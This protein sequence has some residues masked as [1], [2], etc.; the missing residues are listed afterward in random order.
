GMARNTTKKAPRD[1]F[2]RE[3][4]E[5]LELESASFAAESGDL[6]IAASMEE[7]EAQ[8]T[9]A[10]EELAREG[11]EQDDSKEPE[12]GF[13]EPEPAL[14]EERAATDNPPSTENL[15]RVEPA[16]SDTVPPPALLPANDDKQNE[17]YRFARKLERRPSRTV[18]WAA[19]ILSVAWLILGALFTHLVY[20]SQIWQ[21]RS[22]AG[23]LEAP[24]AVSVAVGI[25]MPIVLFW[26]F[27]VMIRRAQEMRLAAQQ[28]AEVAFR[29][30]EPENIAQDRVMMVGQAI[31]REVQAMGDGIERTLARAV[32]L[33]TL[34]HTEVNELERAYSEN[35]ARI[36]LLVDSL[37]A[38]RE[39][40][41]GHAER[42][43]ASITGAHEILKEELD[44]AGEQIRISVDEAAER[45]TGALAQSGNALTERIGSAGELVARS[46][47]E[48]A[49][50]LT[51]QLAASGETLSGLF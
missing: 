28:M 27:A 35:E 25:V 9:M 5:A 3:L 40:I 15:H 16:P 19:A 38:E 32:E 30:A 13:A 24:Y 49:E 37:G 43:R 23:L 11:K 31:R 44:S 26:G 46:L 42:V 8:I 29:L 47:D 6:D 39:G 33:E 18:Y 12:A 7:L 2:A 20:G 22:P 36:R 51:Q 10:A 21:I 50:T 34:V 41:V 48:R 1:D 4:E 17:Y 14:I 45:L